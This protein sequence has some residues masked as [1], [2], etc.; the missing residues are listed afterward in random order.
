MFSGLR[1][2]VR[3][4]PDGWREALPLTWILYCADCGVKMYIHRTNNG[5]RIAQYTCSQYS[6]VSVGVLCGTQHRINAEVVMTLVADMLRAIAE[7][8]KNNRAEF[9]KAVAEVQDTQQNND[10]TGKKKRF[11]TANKRA[12]D[13]EKLMCK[14]YED[15]AL[16]KLHEARYAAL[17]AQYANEQDALSKEISEMEAAING[18]EK[19]R[20]CADKF[21]ALVEK[22][23]NFDTLT[24]PLLFEFVEKIGSLNLAGQKTRLHMYEPCKISSCVN[25][26]GAAIL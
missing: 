10:I 13:L 21:I 20:K 1:E 5:K 12:A 14:I 11:V 19:S 16:G 22:Y 18:Y 17:D 7:Y 2:S 6:K 3:R 4:Y 23:E 15:C 8:S 26:R 24:T 25:G 9:V